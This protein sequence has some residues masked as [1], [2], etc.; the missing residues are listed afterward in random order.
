[1]GV[2]YRYGF[3]GKER[4]PEGM[5]G[6]GSTYDYGFRIYNPQL[7]KFLSVDPLTASYPW[8]TPYQFAGNTP[9]QASDLDGLEPDYKVKMDFDKNGIPIFKIENDGAIGD[10]LQH[11]NVS[12]FSALEIS[13]KEKEVQF[14]NES[15]ARQNAEI[16]IKKPNTA[17]IVKNGI[18][19]PLEFDTPEHAIQST[20]KIPMRIMY[21]TADNFWIMGTRYYSAFTGQGGVRDMTGTLVDHKD[22]TNAGLDIYTG[23]LTSFK[24]PMLRGYNASE[25][26]RVFKGTSYVKRV[27]FSNS[28][29]KFN[30]ER[31]LFNEKAV[32]SS[33][34]F[35]F[36]VELLKGENKAQ[37][38]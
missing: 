7:G 13:E 19:K 25:F 33:K 21:N 31:K 6:G 4:D 26:S 38:K 23:L 35:S 32:Q 12:K 34:Q 5:G 14:K 37:E 24:P 8:Y 28:I 27:N 3:N 10:K 29:K 11:N 20:L 2:G 16:R 1:L 18:Y 17:E 36:G 9:I 30:A 15:D 22:V